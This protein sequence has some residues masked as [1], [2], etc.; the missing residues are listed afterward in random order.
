MNFPGTIRVKITNRD[1]P[2][3]VDVWFATSV[4]W[5]PTPEATVKHLN[6]TAKRNGVNATYE[7]ATEAEYL[8]YK[9]KP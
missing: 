9:R 5:K 8:E 6:A 2:P 3:P 1:L 4:K 7:L